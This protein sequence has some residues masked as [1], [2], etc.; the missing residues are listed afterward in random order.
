L[1]VAPRFLGTSL[2]PVGRRA[3]FNYQKRGRIAAEK[4]GSR[5]RV[6][7]SGFRVQGSGLRELRVESFWE[8]DVLAQRGR[9]FLEMVK[10]R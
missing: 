10:K 3:G 2:K 9:R 5:F 1:V 7:G 8:W 6:Q 4:R